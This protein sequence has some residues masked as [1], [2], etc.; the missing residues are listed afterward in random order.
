MSNQANPKVKAPWNKDDA[1]LCKFIK[2][3]I[4]DPSE[5]HHSTIKK[6]HKYWPH[7]N[8]TTFARPVCTKLRDWETDQVIGGARGKFF[9]L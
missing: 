3:R 6:I 1:K 7:K 9:A 2:E 5:C 4:I 8:F